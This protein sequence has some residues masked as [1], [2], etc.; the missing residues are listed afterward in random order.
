MY[1]NLENGFNPK[2]FDF[3]VEPLKDLYIGD[4]SISQVLAGLSVSDG[5][6]G[7]TCIF[8]GYDTNIRT[9][10][11]SYI[12]N[13]TDEKISSGL[14]KQID[15]HAE[16]IYLLGGNGNQIHCL[17]R[18]PNGTYHVTKLSENNE[19]HKMP[20]L[21]IHKVDKGI[22]ISRVAGPELNLTSLSVRDTKQPHCITC[23]SAVQY[24]PP[25]SIFTTESF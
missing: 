1:H 12:G 3:D 17:E 23:D 19:V 20:T 8:G 24:P 14:E 6:F 7:K 2:I 5:S 15:L 22:E 11:G 10:T 25:D 18:N 4:T 9:K 21:A 16:S 13:V